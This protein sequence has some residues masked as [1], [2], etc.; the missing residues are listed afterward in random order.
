MKKINTIFFIIILILPLLAKSEISFS[1]VNEMEYIYRDRRIE[2]RNYFSNKYQFQMQYKNFRAGLKYDIFFPKHDR[3]LD[4]DNVVNEDD[5]DDIL[6]NSEKNEYYFDEYFLQFETDEIYAKLGT[7]DAVIGS[8]M[9]LHAYYDEDFAEDSRL[10]GLYGQAIFD[11][12]QMQTFYGLMKSD[13]FEDENDNVV[14]ADFDFDLLTSLK[15]G[16]NFTMH[17][18]LT[19][20]NHDQ[21]NQKNIFSERIDY[22]TDFFEIYVEY[23]SSQDDNDLKGSA[24]FSNI[25]TYL[26]KFTLIGEYKNYENFDSKISDLPTANYSDEPLD[27]SWQPGFDEQG[28]MGEIRFLPDYKNEFIINYAEGWSSDY[29]V[30]QADFFS[31]FQHR[32]ENLIF[33]INYH[34]LEQMNENI[35]NWKK[36]L[37]PAVNFDFA[38]GKFPIII[39][40]EYQYIEKEQGTATKSHYEPRIQTDV[41]YDKYSFSLTV[42]N[43]IGQSAEGEDN[44]FW[45]GGEF[46]VNIFNNT[47]LRIFGGKEKGG[48]I[49]RNGVCRYQSEFEGIRVEITTSF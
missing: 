37:T 13:N 46:A 23:A 5:I 26:D 33:T 36:E 11:K 19:D 41:S 16:A 39:K 24:L 22:E 34:H 40:T 8:G 45:I 1:G 32:F 38:L 20:P 12:W 17:Q 30:R 9:V 6:K 7:Y 14:A 47:D 25:T 48:K 4:I 44:E 43:Q 21:Y 42:E 10:T 29:K 35:K 27:D 18:E 28:F 31:E 49:C 2:F 15:V 3:F